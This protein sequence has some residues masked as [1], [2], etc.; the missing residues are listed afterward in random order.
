MMKEWKGFAL[1]VCI[2]L[3]MGGGVTSAIGAARLATVKQELLA[4]IKE[5][6]LDGDVTLRGF[7]ELS[8]AM[9]RIEE[10][11]KAVNEKLDA[12]AR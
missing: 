10:Q 11:L 2:G 8:I 6:E 7:G 4:E 3:I 9:A 5:V 1:S 12:L